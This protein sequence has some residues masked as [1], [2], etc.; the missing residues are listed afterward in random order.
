MKN[1]KY[2]IIGG[3][4]RSA[5]LGEELIKDHKD[6]KAIFI[7]NFYKMSG[8][9]NIIF[10]WKE[11]IRD[12]D[13]II[14]PLPISKDDKNLNCDLENK[15]SLEEII[16][17]IDP[18]KIVMGGG[19]GNNIK[20][21]FKKK[22]INLI[23]YFDREELAI[24]NSIPTAEGALE[25]AMNKLP[26]T[27]YNSRCLVTGFGR[28]SKAL[29]NILLALKAKVTVVA[30]KYEDLA[31]ARILGCEIENFKDFKKAV[32]NQDIIFN[33]VPNKIITEDILKNIRQECLII[34]LASKPGGVDIDCAKNF[35]IKVEWA[36]GLPGKVAP[37]TAGEII[38]QT[39]DNILIDYKNL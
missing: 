21:I 2:L 26:I 38:K 7:E 34:D 11:A 29:V 18:D 15:I 5:Y 28:V 31:W 10:D 1:L 13:V 36:L 39:I 4:I 9:K 6:T 19:A 23:D 16:E 33:T 3:D 24:L 17:I 27:I 30:R 32:K 22:N 35:N 12:S 25:L 8:K 37:K 14:F 20:E